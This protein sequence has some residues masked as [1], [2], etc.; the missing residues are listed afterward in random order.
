MG[1]AETQEVSRRIPEIDQEDSMPPRK[2]SDRTSQQP[3][4]VNNP[5]H[6]TA[7]GNLYAAKAEFSALATEAGRSPE[8][9]CYHIVV[10]DLE[11]LI[12]VTEGYFRP[13]PTNRETS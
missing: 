10:T 13:T 9:R 7:L 3:S 11:K 8:G 6:S 1:P 5:H 4:P 2:R 12:F